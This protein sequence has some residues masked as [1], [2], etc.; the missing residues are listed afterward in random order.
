MTAIAQSL[1]MPQRHTRALVRQPWFVAITIVQPFVW[2]MRRLL[3]K[4]VWRDCVSRVRV[5]V[6][7]CAGAEH[8]R[9]SVVA[10]RHA[11]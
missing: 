9:T 1:Y 11:R 8:P 2:L 4:F 5:R 6:R 7:V 3:Q 10:R